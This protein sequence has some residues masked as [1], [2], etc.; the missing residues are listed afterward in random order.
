MH[1]SGVRRVDGAHIVG[2][3]AAILS[4]EPLFLCLG[5][6]LHLQP[7]ANIIVCFAQEGREHHGYDDGGSQELPQRV[8]DDAVLRG[9]V[10]DDKGKYS[11]HLAR[12]RP[13]QAPLAL[14]RPRVPPPE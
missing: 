6:L 5:R 11:P 4:A 2:N 13:M 7:L 14:N 9:K 1:V 10:E 8:G 12:S 3:V